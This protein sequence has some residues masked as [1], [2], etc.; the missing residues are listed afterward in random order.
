MNRLKHKI[1]LIL[2]L[3]GLIS[4]I[5]RSTSLLNAEIIRGCEVPFQ[6]EGIL[7]FY[8]DLYQFESP[9]D[10][11]LIEVCY[12]LDLSQL[13]IENQPHPEYSFTLVLR[14]KNTEE[15]VLI[16]LQ[17][18]KVITGE[19]LASAG[20]QQFLDL[21]KFY[22]NPDTVLFE[23]SIDDPIS[24]KSGRIEKTIDFVPFSDQLSL[25]DP[26]F[27]SH[28]Q[29][30]T[31]TENVFSRHNVLMIPNPP[32][33]FNLSDVQ[34]FYIYFEINNLFYDQGKPTLYNVECVVEDLKGN[35]HYNIEHFNLEKVGNNTSRIEKINLT[36][37]KTGMYALNITVADVANDQKATKKR[38]FRVLSDDKDPQLVMP[39]EEED[40]KKYRDQIKYIAT[41]REM[42]I[43]EQL[44]A[45]GKQEFLLQFWKA[46]DPTP[47][48]SN[49]EYM[50][51]H[52]QKIDY[53]ENVFKNGVNSDQCRIYIQYGEP[54]DIE[55]IVSALE[56][57]R[58][59]EIWTYNLNGSVEFV[60]V[61]RSNDGQY[62]LMHSTHPDEISNPSWARDFS[63][64]N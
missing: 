13:H 11:L 58:P 34:N 42:D 18:D 28:I 4:I 36:N 6:S 61:D 22:L 41:D 50:V 35:S 60:F 3:G 59:V 29:K 21:Q 10:R 26:V 56:F 33:F 43:F 39:M 12:S 55:R 17:D 46:K 47:N 53:C 48:T 5:T 63:T 9:D 7:L 20:N 32:R 51:K 27:I 25:S 24:G 44:D 23:L 40:I 64:D 8:A 38:F 14:I 45:V 54:L 16:D 15:E 19:S 52:F 30:S 31:D 37:L 49:N 2:L 57:S 1:I 62:M